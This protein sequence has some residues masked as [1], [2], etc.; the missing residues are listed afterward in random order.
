MKFRW[1]NIL[2]V[3]GSIDIVVSLAML[4][5]IQLSADTPLTWIVFVYLYNLAF[6]LIGIG[7]YYLGDNLEDIVEASLVYGEM[8][9]YGRGNRLNLWIWCYQVS[10]G[11]NERN[12]GVP[13]DS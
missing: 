9:Q 1:S 6:L 13:Q 11:Y 7:I 10:K 2:T 5:S 4:C 8:K 12:E 3:V